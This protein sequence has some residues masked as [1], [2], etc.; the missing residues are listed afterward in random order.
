MAG[1]SAGNE[2]GGGLCDFT[3]LAISESGYRRV[4]VADRNEL[5]LFGRWGYRA[6]HVLG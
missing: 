1:S 4:K 3:A 6:E 5:N 2:V